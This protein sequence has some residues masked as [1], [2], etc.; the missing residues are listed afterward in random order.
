MRQAKCGR[1]LKILLCVPLHKGNPRFFQN[2]LDDMAVRAGCG[3]VEIISPGRLS[4]RRG[5]PLAA[6][7]TPDVPAGR[8]F[9]LRTPQARAA[10]QSLALRFKNRLY[11]DQIIAYRFSS[12]NLFRE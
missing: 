12:F 3:G 11:F 6:A 10:S 7:G 5:G 4:G 2:G 8:S 1:F 9:R